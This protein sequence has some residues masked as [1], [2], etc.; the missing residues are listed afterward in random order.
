MLRAI[1]G[2]ILGYAVMFVIVAV[3]LTVA[4]IVLGNDKAFQPGTFD[5]TPLWAGVM[6]G[7]G[8][9]AAVIGGVA[10]ALIAKRGS[11][12]PIGLAVFV[13]IMGALSA[14]MAMG[15]EDPGARTEDVSN[16]DAAM[17]AQQPMWT[18][19]ANPVVGVIGVLVGAKLTGRGSS[20]Q[21]TPSSDQTPAA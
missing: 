4:F 9:V 18:L 15:A 19:V 21:G 12:A 5:I 3:G 2:V 16:M 6:M 7:V 17:K 1:L 20:R 14:V 11:K 8:I 13:L 10:C